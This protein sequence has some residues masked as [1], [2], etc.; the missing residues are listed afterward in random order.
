MDSV[1]RPIEKAEKLD[2]DTLRRDV[3][4]E[5]RDQHIRKERV[6]RRRRR[7]LEYIRSESALPKEGGS[8]LAKDLEIL[9]GAIVTVQVRPFAESL[10][11][12]HVTISPTVSFRLAASD[13]PASTLPSVDL[14][15]MGTHMHSRLQRK[16]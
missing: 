11:T 8:E 13:Q 9:A 6:D 15:R 5:G 2:N 3:R 16:R 1:D 14:R 10:L 4:D 12:L 7:N